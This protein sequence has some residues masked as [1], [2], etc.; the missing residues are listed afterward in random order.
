MNTKYRISF[1]LLLFLTLSIATLELWKS[2]DINTITG[3]EPHYLVM[4]SGMVKQGVLEQTLPYQAEF[5]SREIFKPG[6]APEDAA[7]SPANTHAVQGPRGLFNVHNIGL[8]LLLALP[9]LGFG[10]IGAKIFLVLLSSLILLTTWKIT[11]LLS[12]DSKHRYWA[13]LGACISLPLIPAAGQIYPDILAGLLALTGLYWFMTADKERC[14]TQE[15]A[16]AS[17]LAFMPWLQIKLAATC[18]LIFAAVLL[19]KFLASRNYRKV[20]PILFIGFISCIALACYNYYAFGKVSG[21]Y[22]S[23][24]IEISRTAVM[25]LFGL[26]LDQNQGFLFQN[27]I[28]FIGLIAIGSLYRDNKPFT[29][30]WAL[31]FLSLIVPNAMHHAWYGGGSFSGRF[32]WSATIVFLIPVVYGLM[33]LALYRETLFRVLL[34]TGLLLQ[35]YFFYRYAVEGVWLYNKITT[36]WPSGYSIYYKAVHGGLPMLYNSEW[37][38]RYLPNY[39][40]ITLTSLLFAIGFFSRKRLGAAISGTLALGLLLIITAGVFDKQGI[41][42]ASYE[43]KELPSLT[44]RVSGTSRVAEPGIDSPG[45]ISF[46][47]YLPLQEGEYELTLTYSSNAASDQKI[48]VYEVVDAT[49]QNKMDQGQLNGTDATSKTLKVRFELTKN[50]SQILEFRNFWYGDYD[51]SI[52]QVMLVKLR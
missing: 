31:T 25:V 10:I 46:G 48:G 4:A 16:M 15:L 7:P 29:I 51:L 30:L 26:V 1:L 41:N 45:F 49:S 3:D 21:P 39:A 27:P 33:K 37:A 22:Q 17:A 18:A 8:P 20:L 14:V 34:G 12:S 19:K 32:E 2:Y 5:K 24:A 23:D 11:G 38:F 52:H 13:T 50:K 42:S 28:Y 6:L 43:G 9:Y 47:P 36:S 40:W 44:G 35:C